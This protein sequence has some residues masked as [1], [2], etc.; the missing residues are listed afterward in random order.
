MTPNLKSTR[1]NQLGKWAS[2][3]SLGKNLEKSCVAT[4]SREVGYVTRVRV[5]GS[6]AQIVEG[7]ETCSGSGLAS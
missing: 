2:Q 1:R 7:C 3:Y 6:R 4:A 5:K